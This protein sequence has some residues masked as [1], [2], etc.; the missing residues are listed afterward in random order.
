MEDV[1]PMLGLPAW[2]LW[3]YVHWDVILAYLAAIHGIA[4]VIVNLTP[5]P[6]DDEFLAKYYGA[7]EKIA[8]IVTK[9]A[10]QP[11]NP[12]AAD[13]LKVAA[14]SPHV[15][16]AAVAVAKSLPHPDHAIPNPLGLPDPLGIMA[17]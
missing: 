2:V 17:K 14:V 10:K 11:S 6:K 9:V 4:A 3:A 16:A 13:V 5:T 15:A 1:I 12:L 7:L 8:G